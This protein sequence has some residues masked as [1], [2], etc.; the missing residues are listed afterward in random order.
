MS[1]LGKL[2]GSARKS[3]IGFGINENCVLLSV[4]NDE[5]KNANNEIIKRNCYTKIAALDDNG[6]NVAEREIFWFNLDNTQEKVFE[7]FKGQLEQLS[8]IVDTFCP[9]GEKDIW[10][11]AFDKILENAGVEATK[12]ALQVAVKDRSKLE[13][14]TSSLYATYVEILQVESGKD[15]AEKHPVRFKVAYDNKGNNLGAPKYGSIIESMTVPFK[16]STLR[17]TKS[18][19]DNKVKADNIAS[20][21]PTAGAPSNI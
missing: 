13:A 19:E 9:A 16:D 6:A 7:Q 18:D 1:L 21:K 8:N 10:D 17:I 2:M 3:E 14:I 20:S 4:N 11:M 5:R 12:E 15:L